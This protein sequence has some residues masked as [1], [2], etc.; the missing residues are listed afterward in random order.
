MKQTK[1]VATLGPASSSY[2]T[3]CE[4]VQAG[5][6]VARIN[7]SHGVWAEH[8]DKIDKIKKIRKDMNTSVGIMIDTRGPE[9][10]IGNFEDSKAQLVEGQ[11]F[12]LVTDN[13]LGDHTRAT[14]N[15]PNSISLLNVGDKV[16]ACNALITFEVTEIL[17][18]GVKM[19][20]INGGEISN[21][22][23]LSFPG[24]IF[25]FS[26][27]NDED[28]SDIVNA[29]KEGVEYIA[30]SFVNSAKDIEVVRKF[31]K[32]NGGDIK[33]I[34]KIESSLGISNI[35]EIIEASDGIM[36]ARGDL[37][38]ELPFQSIP[39]LQKMIIRKCINANKIVITATEMLES[40]INSPRPTRAETSDVA[41][42][43]FDGSSA[44]MLSGESAMGKFPVEAIKVMAKICEETE[45]F[46]DY[47]LLFEEEE[48]TDQTLSNII[49]RTVAKLAFKI[50]ELKAVAVY[51][52]SGHTAMMISKH[53][54]S[55]PIVALTPDKNTYYNLSSV[56]G[57]YPV[58]VKDI[59]TADKLIVEIDD[60]VQTKKYAKK[61]E[62]VLIGT[63]TRK[64]TSTD[65]I[66]IHIVGQ[67]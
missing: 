39:H 51:T 62:M 36:V 35:D 24:K 58:L 65:I 33:I 63:G 55:C 46:V 41:N 42:A 34:S 16:L 52:Q 29:I 67:K 21:H 44:V 8:K 5:M 13:I 45:K 38:V 50:K 26:Y 15:H 49:S 53:F 7:L 23:S 61:G 19:K 17:P 37:G 9:L 18:N 28:K 31:I 20:V 25:N 14:I 10:R 27:L 22:K 32:D 30:C 59:K 48:Q 54:P 64:P 12:S 43:V 47:K 60:I 11:Y 6:N 3:L 40:M 1:I 4:M 2:V 57:V 56:W 66:K